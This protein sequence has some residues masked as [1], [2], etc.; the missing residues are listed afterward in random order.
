MTSQCLTD[1]QIQETRNALFFVRHPVHPLRC[2]VPSPL[3]P[4]D[5]SVRPDNR[6]VAV[7]KSG[8]LG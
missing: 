1:L 5:S 8:E 2:S 6:P 4:L 7:E 3:G